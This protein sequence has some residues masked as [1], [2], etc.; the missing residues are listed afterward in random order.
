MIVYEEDE[1]RIEDEVGSPMAWPLRDPETI[2]R[3]PTMA[4]AAIPRW[5]QILPSFIHFWSE[6][7]QRHG[8]ATDDEASLRL[9]NSSR[10]KFDKK[11]FPEN[12]WIP[13]K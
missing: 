10:F 7:G 3:L 6:M 9:N 2:G 12:S 4:K 13:D 5:V 1:A 11:V 8:R